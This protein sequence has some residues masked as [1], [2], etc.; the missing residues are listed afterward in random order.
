M[1]KKTTTTTKM[2]KEKWRSEKMKLRKIPR[3]VL[4][5]IP[6]TTYVLLG[7]HQMDVSPLDQ[8]ADEKNCCRHYSLTVSFE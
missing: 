7:K 3:P 5:K 2:M 1:K 8:T 6:K 4:Y